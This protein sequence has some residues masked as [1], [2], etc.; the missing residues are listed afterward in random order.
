MAGE[1]IPY[2]ILIPRIKELE[3]QGWKLWDTDLLD[4]T[5]MFTK[6]FKVKNIKTGKVRDKSKDKKITMRKGEWKYLNAVATALTFGLEPP[7]PSSFL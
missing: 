6:W 2:A 7:S 5:F 1:L 4:L 3:K